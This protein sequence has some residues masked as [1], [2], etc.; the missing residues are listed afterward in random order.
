MKIVFT[1]P[2]GGTSIMNPA[3]QVHLA[4]VMPQVAD[5]TEQEYVEFIR[6][7]DVPKDAANIRIVEDAE[8]PADRTFR[9]ALKNDLTHDIDKCVEITKERLRFDRAPLLADLDTQFI[10][11]LREGKQ[12]APNEAERQRLLDITLIPNNTMTLDELRALKAAKE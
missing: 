5:M 7:R 8:I 11:A 12:T 3:P 10:I 4:R 6:D 2:D 9:N 1:R